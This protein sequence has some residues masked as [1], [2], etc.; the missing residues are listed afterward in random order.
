[1]IL[2]IVVGA[3]SV[4]YWFIKS[5]NTLEHVMLIIPQ[6]IH[7]FDNISLG[8]YILYG[9]LHFLIFP[10]QWPITIWLQ[11]CNQLYYKSN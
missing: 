7:I 6:T 10:N 4:L 3:K 2:D 8:I 1:M 5:G 9:A 11:Y